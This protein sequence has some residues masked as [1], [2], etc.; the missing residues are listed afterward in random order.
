MTFSPLLPEPFAFRGARRGRSPPFSRGAGAGRRC[1]SRAA[2]LMRPLS[3]APERPLSHAPE[4][5]SGPH[6]AVP[7]MPAEEAESFE[8]ED[9]RG[10]LSR[11]NFAPA[12]GIGDRGTRLGAV[13]R[14]CDCAVI[15]IAPQL[16]L[17]LRRNCDCAAIARFGAAAFSYGAA[18]PGGGG[19]GW[20]FFAARNSQARKRTLSCGP[21][22]SGKPLP[23]LP[24][25]AGGRA[26]LFA[27]PKGE[28]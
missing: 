10:A 28:S 14:C 24:R 16:Q 22:F 4:V 23:S 5:Q 13:A 15:A 11:G 19:G 27:A 6:R 3:H 8:A 7:R 1:D 2:P 25:G 9:E 26:G 21:V 12:D 18:A 17:R 20:A